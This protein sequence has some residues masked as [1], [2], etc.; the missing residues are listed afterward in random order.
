MLN[1]N[2]MRESLGSTKM[3]S[4]LEHWFQESDVELHGTVEIRN[5][6]NTYCYF[7]KPNSEIILLFKYYQDSNTLTV[8]C[9][10]TKCEIQQMVEE[11]GPMLLY[12]YMTLLNWPIKGTDLVGLSCDWPLEDP[13]NNVRTEEGKSIN[14]IEFKKLVKSGTLF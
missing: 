2:Q 7:V 14:L 10:F 6:L 9:S 8:E 1:I 3:S 5:F 12:K 11:L 13:K 4:S